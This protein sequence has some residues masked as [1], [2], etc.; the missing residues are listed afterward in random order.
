M[1]DTVLGLTYDRSEAKA[2]DAV[3]EVNDRVAVTEN[4]IGGLGLGFVDPKA[5]R[6]IDPKKVERPLTG[7]VIN[8]N[9]R[10]GRQ[11]YLFQNRYKSILC[12]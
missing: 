5:V 7:Y 10:R 6:V 1:T 11:G 2:L 8:F 3:K 9:R 4:G 12:L